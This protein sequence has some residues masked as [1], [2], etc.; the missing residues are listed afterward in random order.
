M[1]IWCEIEL[2]YSQNLVRNWMKIWCEI[3]WVLVRECQ[4]EGQALYLDI[5][6]GDRW[7]F[8]CVFVRLSP[9]SQCILGKKGAHPV[10]LFSWLPF[11]LL[12]QLESSQLSCCLHHNHRSDLKSRIAKSTGLDLDV[13]AS[14]TFPL[15]I[16]VWFRIFFLFLAPILLSDILLSIVS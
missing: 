10:Q 6:I 14:L 4:V 2:F 15:I 5:N 16:K 9:Q 1:K 11:Y 7:D 13:A 12:A 8:L 3:E